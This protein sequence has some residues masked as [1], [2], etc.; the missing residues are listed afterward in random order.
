MRAQITRTVSGN[1]LQDG[2]LQRAWHENNE[3]LR[4][5]GVGLTGIAQRSDLTPDTLQ[6]LRSQAREGA[7]SMADELEMEIEALRDGEYFAVGLD[8]F[9]GVTHGNQEYT[10]ETREE[11]RERDPMLYEIITRYF[12]TDEWSPMDYAPE[13]YTDSRR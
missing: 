9:Y 8:C 2:I 6:I 13:I 1:N 3:N 4:L 12:P 7:N 11:M 10:L 5:C